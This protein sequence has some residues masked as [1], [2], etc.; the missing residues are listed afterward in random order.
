VDGFS[1]FGLWNTASAHEGGCSL[2]IAL[3]F[4]QAA[5]K[6]IVSS[7]FFPRRASD[8]SR[9]ALRLV[10]GGEGDERLRVAQLMK[11]DEEERPVCIPGG[12]S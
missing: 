6:S 3:H 7:V 4:F 5:L 12:G 8:S 1:E 10:E 9:I 11:R 2:W